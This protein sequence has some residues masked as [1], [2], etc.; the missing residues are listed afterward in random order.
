MMRYGTT[1]SGGNR[2]AVVSG[3]TLIEALVATALMGVILAALG[4]ITAQWLPNWN[5]GIAR[6][7][8]SELVS[9]ALN[10]L[11][12]DL[13]ASEFIPP[14]R[15]TEAPLFDGT[16]FSVTLVRS[17]LGPNPRPG[18]EIVHIAE[19]ADKSGKVLVRSI[20]PFV[21]FGPSTTSVGQLEFANPV[22]L[23]RAPYR[24]SFAYAGRDGIWK[25][26]WRNANE[27]PAAVRLTVR[28]AASERTL[29]ISTTALVHI[30]MP[31]A[32][33]GGKNKRDCIGRPGE[34]NE[35]QDNNP[36]QATSAKQRT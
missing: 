28:D 29:S 13:G 32:C 12:A 35:R 19:S 22:V 2:H 25:N 15:D 14:N 20:K 24:V 21:P 33:V 1:Q 27:L 10:R 34:D 16:E 9:I 18:L 11:V 4:S 3:F 17:A 6:A 23:L 31:A 5:R 36:A 7:Q 8:R 26:T 30:D